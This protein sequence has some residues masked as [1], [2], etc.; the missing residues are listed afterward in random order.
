MEKVEYLFADVLYDKL[1]NFD[2]SPLPETIFYQDWLNELGLMGWGLVSV[3]L[4]A[5]FVYKFTIARDT[6]QPSLVWEYKYVHVVGNI[7]E[8]DDAPIKHSILWET[9]LNL[10]GR[11]R[12]QLAGEMTKIRS[13]EFWPILKRIKI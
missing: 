3:R 8:V 11:N 12:W 13:R 1:V 2:G 5:N 9:W 6:S 4:L 7:V 10:Q